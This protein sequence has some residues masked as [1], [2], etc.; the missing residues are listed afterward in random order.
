VAE[1]EEDGLK[2][3]GT[4][5]PNNRGL[6]IWLVPRTPFEWKAELGSAFNTAYNAQRG[7][8]T[9]LDLWCAS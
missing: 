6:V 7:N 2:S 1:A 9:T 8:V 3:S 4:T 5:A